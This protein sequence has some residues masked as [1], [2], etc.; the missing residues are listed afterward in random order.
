VHLVHDFNG[1]A[2]LVHDAHRQLEVEVRASRDDVQQQV[3]AR[4]RR[5]RVD[6]SKRA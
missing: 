2:Q 4:V 6:R 5:A 1:I 3:T